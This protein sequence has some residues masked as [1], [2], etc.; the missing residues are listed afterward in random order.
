[1]QASGKR[2]EVQVFDTVINGGIIVN[3]DGEKRVDI[4]ISGG[5]VVAL[6]T[7]GETVAARTVV[8]AAGQHLLPGLIDAHAH[9][10]EPGLTH[11]EDFESGT[12]AAALGGVTTILDMPTDDPWTATAAQLSDK[13]A[14]AEGRLHVD[15]GFQAVISKS[16][17]QIDE[18]LALGPVSLELFTA[19]VPADFMF[20]TLDAVTEIL[21][22]LAG[23]GTLIGVSPGDQSILAGSASR[24]RQDDIGAFL[25]GRPPLAE[26]GGIARAILAA[27]E[28]GAPVHVRQVNS[29]LGVDVWRRLRDMADAT[30]ETTPQNLFFTADDY[31]TAGANLKGSPPLRGRDDVDALRQAVSEGLIDIMATDHAPHGKAEKSAPHGRFADIPGGMPGLQTLLPVMLDLVAQGVID[32]AGLVRMCSSTPARRFG[33]GRSKGA[34][35]VGFDADIACVDLRRSHVISHA[36]Q[37]SRAGY[38]PFDGRRIAGKLTDVFLRGERIV[39]DGVVALPNRGRVARRTH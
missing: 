14:M 16:Y 31:A 26:G 2:R 8:D 5:R 15:V 39:T 12:R 3:A 18:L 10:R 27:A 11:K 9:L 21:R 22:R 4:G 24:G 30:V 19:D 32:L 34:I 13:M 35:A 25:A 1:L 37:A 38:T 23:C 7:P 33:L 29:K 20:D 36:E 17:A 6:L 28:S